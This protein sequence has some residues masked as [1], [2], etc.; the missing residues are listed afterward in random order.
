MGLLLTVVIK[1]SIIKDGG[2]GILRKFKD[3]YDYFRH[4]RTLGN[5]I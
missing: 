2:V 5:T 3:L 4:F 1:L